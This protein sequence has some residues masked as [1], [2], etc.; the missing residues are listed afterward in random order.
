LQNAAECEDLGGGPIREVGESA[1][2][3]FTVEAGALAQEDGGRGIAVGDG[4]YV[5]VY[6]ITSIAQ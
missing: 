6:I 5:P 3:N 4:F 1:L 2:D